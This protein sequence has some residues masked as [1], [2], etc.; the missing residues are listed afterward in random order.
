MAKLVVLLLCCMLVSLVFGQHARDRVVPWTQ[1]IQWENNGHVYSLLSTGTEYH[2]P[3][4][5][6]RDSRVYLSSR[7]QAASPVPPGEAFA[8]YRVTTSHS[9]SSGSASTVMGPDGRHYILASGRATGARLAHLVAPLRQGPAGAPGARRYATATTNNT[10]IP[11]LTE[12]SGSGVPRRPTSTTDVDQ[13]ANRVAGPLSTDIQELHPESAV[14]TNLESTRMESVNA[15]QSYPYPTITGEESVGDVAATAPGPLGTSEEEATPDN[16]V[17]DDP[18]NPLKNH[19]NTVF[20]N[21]YPSGRRAGT[22]RTRRPPPGTGYGTR[23][24]HNGLPDLV[25]DP[26]SIQSGTYIQRMQMY[27]LRCAA[28]ENCLA[29]S[30]YRPTVRDLDYRVLLR[31][32][33]KVQNLGTAD[34]LPVKPRHQWE[35]HSCHQHYHSMDA[36]SLYDLLDINT[37]RKVAEGHK[38]SFCLEDTGCNPGF[39]RRY[40]CTA[41]TQG[42]S[43][44][45]HDTYA[46]NID[47]QWIDITDVPPGNYILKITVNPNYLVPES[48]FSNNVVRCEVFYSGHQVQ[49]RHCRITRN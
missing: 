10:N 46:A 26:Y 40:A 16:M 27:A 45:C 5:S 41:H 8:H 6:R 9:G 24:F 13:S 32:P 12:F 31:F 15:H 47:C 7:S 39:R 49:T 18:R 20:Y 25:P 33:Q 44:G 48:D 35:W 29:R 38:A 23:Y 1:R 42:L 30:A 21:V 37:G 3:L 34:F 19:R 11:F 28:E 17:G 2:S 43:P 4:H 36:F 22:A 14:R